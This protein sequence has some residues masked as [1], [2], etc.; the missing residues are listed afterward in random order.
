MNPTP[1]QLDRRKA[2]SK[3][4]I[5]LIKPLDPED[6]RLK[7][8]ERNILEKCLRRKQ[9][10]SKVDSSE[11]R[12]FEAKRPAAFP[13]TRPQ[14]TDQSVPGLSARAGTKPSDNTPSFL[15]SRRSQPQTARIMLPF[16]R[17]NSAENSFNSATL[18]DPSSMPTKR[19]LKTVAP[20]VELSAGDIT[21][22]QAEGQVAT[23]RFP[24]DRLVGTIN[25]KII[26]REAFI[27]NEKRPASITKFE[28][29]PKSLHRMWPKKSEQNLADGKTDKQAKSQDLKNRKKFK[30]MYKDLKHAFNKRD[31]NV[32]IIT[33]EQG[34]SRFH[35]TSKSA[36][37]ARMRR[38]QR[39]Q[40]STK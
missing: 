29:Q 6:L 1:R 18:K 11:S 34:S 14:S 16:S 35:Q 19:T 17:L 7:S 24:R 10:L 2:G 30:V 36:R 13:A 20:T 37:E 3:V 25:R 28:E 8:V 40:E 26:S 5:S 32:A 27:L 31:K 4:L 9:E 39:Y 15:L 21:L 12:V 23:A 38:S 22:N 33:T